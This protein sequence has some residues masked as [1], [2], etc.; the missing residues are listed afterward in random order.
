M[1]K[2]KLHPDYNP[3]TLHV[4][5]D[6]KKSLTPVSNYF[7]G[8]LQYWIKYKSVM[9]KFYFDKSISIRLWHKGDLTIIFLDVCYVVF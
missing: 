4:P 5:G 6:F 2:P 7:L 9:K 1:G 3:K 8:W